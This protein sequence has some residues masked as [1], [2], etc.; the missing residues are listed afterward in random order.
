MVS[1]MDVSVNPTGF[2]GPYA[3][4]FIP[5]PGN[6]TELSTSLVVYNFLA[7]PEVELS[8]LPIGHIDVRD[9]AAAMV[10]SIKVKGT[11]RLLL[12]GEWFDYADAVKH[13]AAT[14]PELTPRLIKTTPTGQNRP[15]ID[16]K[17]AFE[18]LGITL[19]PWKKTIDDGLDSVLKLEKD[20][21]E[22]GVDLTPLKNNQWIEVVKGGAHIR[23]EFID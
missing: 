19:T 8:T 6:I 13:I 15:I 23:V 5:T 17:K 1:L 3:E 9:I 12:T 22:G 18:V 10:A 16:N 7:G 21:T 2:I 20:W 11:H 4:G 14:R